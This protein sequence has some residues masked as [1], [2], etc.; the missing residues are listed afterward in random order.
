MSVRCQI[1]MPVTMYII[2]IIKQLTFL[3]S[4]HLK[5]LPDDRNTMHAH[6]V[7]RSVQH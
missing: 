7:L 2:Y 5:Y 3:H 6:I 1:T 4:S